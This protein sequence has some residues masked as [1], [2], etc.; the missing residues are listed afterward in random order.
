M[1]NE[2]KF[3]EVLIDVARDVEAI[4]TQSAT[5][6]HRETGFG[7]ISITVEVRPNALIVRAPNRATRRYAMRE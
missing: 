3:A 1:A 4:A 2:R 5:E 7:D 6:I